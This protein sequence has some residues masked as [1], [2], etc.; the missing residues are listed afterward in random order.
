MFICKLQYLQL[1]FII[2]LFNR[3]C[4]QAER[5]MGKKEAFLANEETSFS[6]SLDSVE[7]LIK[8]HKDFEKTLQGQVTD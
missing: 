3:D 6:K 7:V 2:Q 5:W 4:E 1:F 8:K